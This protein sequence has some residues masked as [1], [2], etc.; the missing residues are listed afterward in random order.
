MKRKIRVLLL[1][2]YSNWV[3]SLGCGIGDG[4]CKDI[5]K[6]PN[7]TNGYDLGLQWMYGQTIPIPIPFPPTSSPTSPNFE[8]TTLDNFIMECKGSEYGKLRE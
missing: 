1:G 8:Q 6:P 4:L 5:T 2:A 7:Q 3:M